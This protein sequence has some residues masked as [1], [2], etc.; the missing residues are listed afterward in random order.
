MLKRSPNQVTLVIIKQYFCIKVFL[1]HKF[2]PKPRSLWVSSFIS[3]LVL[4]EAEWQLSWQLTSSTYFFKY[5]LINNLQ[6]QHGEKI[7]VALL[8]MHL[9]TT[10]SNQKKIIKVVKKLQFVL[11]FFAASDSRRIRLSKADLDF[12]FFIC[13]MTKRDY[14]YPSINI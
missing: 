7:Q 4:T 10:L 2:H 14:S 11:V 1:I 6:H 5:N 12:A 3:E 9:F 8:K 13:S